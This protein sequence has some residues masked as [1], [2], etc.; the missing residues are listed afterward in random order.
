MGIARRARMQAHLARPRAF[1]DRLLWIFGSPR[2]G[3]TW[4]LQLLGEHP[5]VIPMNE[6]LIGW[7]LSPF[8]SDEPGWS[9]NGLTSA[10]FTV[11]RVQAEKPD[12][13]FA[14][15]F[16]HVWSPALGRLMRERFLAHA[17]RYRAAVPLSRSI[18]AIKEP[19]GSGAADVIVRA[20]PHSRLLF[21]LRDGRDVVDSDLA[22][23]LKG[24][25]TT[26]EFPGAVGLSD[27]DRREFVRQSAHKWL[28]RTEVVEEAYA[29]HPGPKL[30]MR[31]EK[32]LAD[33]QPHLASLIEW[34]GLDANA[35]EIAAAVERHS[36]ERLP[37]SERGP[38]AFFRAAS[39][40][41]WRENLTAAE[42]EVL[43]EVLGDKL[44]ALG[45][46]T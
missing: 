17:L 32:I 35:P 39:P 22:A 2:S 19:N 42:Q 9:V 46:Q 25:W 20:L 37:E 29:G 21:L 24:S 34:L 5:A 45:Y 4:L 13:F 33:P 14:R 28:W 6:P 11:R 30:L 26:R 12:Q 1:D 41:L 7:Y 8:L 38:Q 15:E 27:E 43:L 31:Y 44:A 3:S 40:G 10:D 16:E 23:R 36:F 18:V